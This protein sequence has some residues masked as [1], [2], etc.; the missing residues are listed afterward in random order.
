MKVLAKKLVVVTFKNDDIDILYKA[1]GKEI[2][3]L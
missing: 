3:I 1:C 2:D